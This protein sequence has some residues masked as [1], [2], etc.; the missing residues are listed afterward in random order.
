[1]ENKSQVYSLI[2]LTLLC[3]AFS[4]RVGNGTECPVPQ[5]IVKRMCRPAC[6]IFRAHFYLEEKK[7][8]QL[9]RKE[10]WGNF[11]PAQAEL[12]QGCSHTLNC[13]DQRCLII[14]FKS[15]MSMYFAYLTVVLEQPLGLSKGGGRYAGADWL[16]LTSPADG[17]K[18]SLCIILPSPVH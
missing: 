12:I 16:K 6:F 8:F 14:V 9:L 2:C 18:R 17:G 5:M 3:F 1:M 10:K 13:T 15:S 7:A 11:L 4:S